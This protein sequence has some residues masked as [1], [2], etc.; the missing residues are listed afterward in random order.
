MDIEHLKIWTS[1]HVHFP[2]MLEGSNIHSPAQ[3]EVECSKFSKVDQCTPG[4]LAAID[5][6]V[7]TRLGEF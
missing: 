4:H 1:A 3:V 2:S 7:S 6:C 5:R